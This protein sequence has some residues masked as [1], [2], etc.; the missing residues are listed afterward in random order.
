MY[1]V[2]TMLSGT[3]LP[4]RKI[5]LAFPEIARE[6]KKSGNEVGVH[7]W[8]HVG[9]QDELHGWAESKIREE[10]AKAVSA[11]GEVFGEKPK[12]SA[13]PAW[14]ALGSSLAVQEE[15]ALD[16][17]SDCRTVDWD[18]EG[19]FLPKFEGRA[20]KTPQIAVSL[21]TLDELL[22]RQGY[23]LDLIAKTWL[24]AAR[25]DSSVVTIHAEAEGRKYQPWFESVCQTMKDRGLAFGTLR[26]ILEIGKAKEKHG[27]KTRT[28]AL[29]EIAG[30]AGK[31]LC[32][33][34]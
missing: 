34:K 11:F 32:V 8:D 19:P 5:A 18:C 29:G 30:R 14:Y 12:T 6:F 24:G 23:T 13:A 3:L 4:A 15:F 28:V 25:R 1:G 2:R 16:Y 27:L 31:V 22:G 10:F 9:W 17:S 33:S 26:E 20:F 7:A 21:P